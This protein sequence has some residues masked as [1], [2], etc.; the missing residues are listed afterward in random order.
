MLVQTGRTAPRSEAAG[1]LGLLVVTSKTSGSVP[2][3]DAG[4]QLADRPAR[5]AGGE[6][7]LDHL[8]ALDG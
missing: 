7:L 6:E 3:V 1:K 2:G 5:Q 8:H 4:Q